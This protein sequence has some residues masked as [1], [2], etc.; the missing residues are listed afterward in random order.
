MNRWINYISV[1]ASALMLCG[2]SLNAQETPDYSEYERLLKTYVDGD[3]VRYAVWAENPGDVAAIQEFVTVLGQT[4]IDTLS[5]ADQTAFYIN[6]YNAAMLE[7]ILENY[8][9][10]SVKTIGI[11]PFSIFKKDFIG[12]AE[13]KVSLDDIEKGIL[14]KQYFDPRIH[15]AVNCASESCAPLRAEPFKGNLLDQQLEEQTVLFAE[16][17]RA[18]QVDE[19]NKSIA[20]SELFKWYAGDFD[21]ENPAEYL[22]R[23]RN[24]A[25]PISYSVDW[26]NYDWSLNEI[27][28][29]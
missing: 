13:R 21:V 14:L 27:K 16:S 25:L 10:K 3:K 6:L 11:L 28:E 19:E 23:Y 12:L 29:N 1:L 5:K 15:F 4:E 24:E 17:D 2:L 9:V 7:V 26:I 20:Y 18:A 22:N 8:P